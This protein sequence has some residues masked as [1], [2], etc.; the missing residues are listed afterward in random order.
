MFSCVAHLVS[1]EVYDRRDSTR[2]FSGNLVQQS[3]QQ[4]AVMNI[5]EAVLNAQGGAAVREAGQSVGLSQDQTSSALS[6]LVPALAAGLQKNSSQPGGL[7]SL[8]GALTGGGH[9]RYVDDPST[10]RR[11]DVVTDG[12]AILGHILGTKDASRA[13]AG[14]A[15]AQTGL[16]E[17]VLK[18]LLPVAATL[19]MGSLAK[20]QL[21]STAAQVGGTDG[22]G[23]IGMLTPLLDQNR[24]G[25]MMDDILGHAGK[26][27]GGR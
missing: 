5:L 14:R 23:I 6:A 24:D 10:L 11:E 26:L 17:D 25:S 8:L 4:E 3:R 19:V 22:G 12:N 16:G 7:E 21:G 13:V 20:Q 15:A 18:K 1:S 9:S 2:V 27:F